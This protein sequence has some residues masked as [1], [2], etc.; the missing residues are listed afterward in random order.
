MPIP[1]EQRDYAHETK[2]EKKRPGAHDA[3]MERQRA[4][5]E[6][7]KKGVVRKGKDIAHK[8]ALANGGS[9]K[10]GFTLQ[11]PKTNRSFPR[12]SNH[13]PVK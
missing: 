2:L 11:A 5:R 8:K 1:K 3:R 12:K 13:K 4:R 9:N 7:D 6:L 10:D